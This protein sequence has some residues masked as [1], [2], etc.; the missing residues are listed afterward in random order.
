M[1][2]ISRIKGTDNKIL[3]IKFIRRAVKKAKRD[4]EIWLKKFSRQLENKNIQIILINPGHVDTRI[5]VE[6]INFGQGAIKERS[7]SALKEG[8]FRDPIIIS[9][10]VE[11]Y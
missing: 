7:L 9:N 10:K 8:K 1:R 4:V 6:A 3:I 2:T 5:N 11:L